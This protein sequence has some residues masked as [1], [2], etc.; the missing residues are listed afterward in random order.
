VV[1]RG[2]VGEREERFRIELILPV[3]LRGARVREAVIHVDAVR[4]ADPVEDGVEDLP[5]AFDALKPS[6]RK[7]LSMRAGCERVI[8]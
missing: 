3:A 4:R 1:G 7:S 5:V 6:V 2:L 8:V